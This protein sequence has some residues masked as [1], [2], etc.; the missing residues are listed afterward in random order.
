M[1]T[2]NSETSESL[3]SCKVKKIF[4]IESIRE[5]IEIKKVEITGIMENLEL[6]GSDQVCVLTVEEWRTRLLEES[7]CR[8]I[9]RPGCWG[10]SYM[11][12]EVIR[13]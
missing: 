6:T 4:L 11:D 1:G 12:M 5:K 13:L 3:C 10:V 9:K 7:G 2:R 8:R